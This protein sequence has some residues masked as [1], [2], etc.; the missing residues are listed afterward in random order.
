ML[1]PRTV[2]LG[3]LGAFL[4]AAGCSGSQY[5]DFKHE[6]QLLRCDILA[7]C[8]GDTTCDHDQEHVYDLKR[9]ETFDA[10]Q[11]DR[12]I[13]SLESFLANAEAHPTTCD[14]GVPLFPECF[15]VTPRRERCSRRRS[16]PV[17][18]RPITHDGQW[19]LAEITTGDAWSG[20]AFDALPSDGH[21]SQIAAQR[22]LR[23][24]RAEHAS[25]AA[26]NRIALEL[27]AVGAPPSLLQQ[28]QRAAMD[29]IRHA[30]LALDI[31]RGLGDRSW[32]FGPLAV[33][34]ARSVTLEQIAVDA[35]LEGCI[36]EGAAAAAA[37]L[38]ADRS[39]DEIA[40]V[41]R[42]IAVDETRH[43]ALA[44]ATVRWALEQDPSLS[45][46]LRAALTE[47]RAERSHAT[48]GHTPPALA[49]LGVVVPEEA[50]RIELEV[51]DGI[52]EPIVSTLLGHASA[53][54]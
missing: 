38:S 20:V 21:E 29:E 46:P 15:N 7:E 48:T 8:H 11:A 49:R 52:V 43:A 1:L 40:T 51:I 2:H 32:D 34:P 27:M 42:I 9:C 44:W 30:G 18:G 19:V 5:N 24:A 25:I 28:C 39:R 41:Q 23:S 13:T 50:L 37:H 4:T 53:V 22:W 17:D 3:L 36:G 45:G 26:F 54:V 47:A 6:E 16:E 33:V 31:A 14:S 35:L 12:C 10:D